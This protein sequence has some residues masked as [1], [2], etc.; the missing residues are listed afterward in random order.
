VLS[1]GAVLSGGATP[2]DGGGWHE[3]SVGFEVHGSVLCAGVVD[4]GSVVVVLLGSELGGAGVVLVVVGDV[5]AGVVVVLVVPVVPEL[6]AAA[7]LGVADW[8]S[9]VASVWVWVRPGGTL[10]LALAFASVLPVVGLVCLG[11]GLA[12]GWAALGFAGLA[13]WGCFTTTGW[14]TTTWTAGA[15]AAVVGTAVVWLGTEA[16]ALEAA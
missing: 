8:A 5:L 4:V 9:T 6:P 2:P 15:G 13:L 7:T 16:T 11:I 3:G 1:D 14:C 10:A 12:T